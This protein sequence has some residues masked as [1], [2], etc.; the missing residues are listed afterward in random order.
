MDAKSHTT[1]EHGNNKQMDKVGKIEVARSSA[2]GPR[3]SIA[4]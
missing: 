2:E 4:Q 1:E 3:L